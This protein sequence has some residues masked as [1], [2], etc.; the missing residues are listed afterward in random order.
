MED[1]STSVVTLP[2]TA[3]SPRLSRDDRREQLLDVAA[4][5]LSEGG[6]PG[7]TMEGLAER[8]GVSKALPYAHF[9]NARAVQRALYRRES[10]EM[11][12]RVSAAA[13]VC[14]DADERVRAA[15]HAYFE[16]VAERGRLLVVITEPIVLAA[17]TSTSTR[18][19][20]AREW[21]EFV[22]AL[23]LRPYNLEGQHALSIASMVVGALGGALDSWAY[24]DAKR[25]VI[26]RTVSDMIIGGIRMTMS[27]SG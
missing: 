21:P 25:T 24:A 23:L 20:R 16:V 7:L 22:A 2:P 6:L 12:R 9:D 18:S 14:T 27:A 26:E 4:E 13:D 1:S 11:R 15:V 3:A 10:D 5:I 8:A 17:S 19:T